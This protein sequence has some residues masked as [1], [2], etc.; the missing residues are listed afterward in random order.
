MIDKHKSLA[1]FF[2]SLCLIG[3]LGYA[4]YRVWQ[5]FAT[6]GQAF[7][8][9]IA[10]EVLAND[11]PE[12][13]S[14]LIEYLLIRSITAS[15]RLNVIA[16]EDLTAYKQKTESSEEETS[17]PIIMITSEVYPKLSG[18]V[19]FVT[20]KYKGRTK[21]VRKFECKGSFDL[22]STQAGRIHSFIADYSDGI[23][24]EIEGG[25]TFSQ[26][27]T[28]NP[29]ALRNF[30]DGEK[31]HKKLETEE[32]IDAYRT[33]LEN[34]AE[35]SLAR[36][37]LADVLVF[38][39]L[40]EDAREN[41]QEAL[42]RKDR[43]I[44]YDLL[45]LRALMSRLN[46]DPIQERQYIR[47]LKEAFPFDKEHHYEFAES[48]FNCGDAEEA[49][50]HYLTALE[51]DPNFSRAHNH[52]AF[53]YSWLGRHVLAEQHFVKYVELDNTAN[54]YDSLASG[55]MFAGKYEE[56][57]EA[58]NKGIIIDPKL[59]YM[60][61]GLARNYIL[62]G[63]LT[64]ARK[65][66]QKDIDV[67]IRENSKANAHFYIAYLELMR[68]NLGRAVQELEPVLDFYANE[69]Y[70]NRIDDLANQPFWL[71]GFIAAER[72][73][74]EKLGDILRI[75]GQ[76][77]VENKVNATNYFP[78]YKFYI[79]LKI[80]EAYLKGDHIEVVRYMDE[81]KRIRDRMGYWY[82]MFDMAFFFDDYARILISL[83][84]WDDA[85]QFLL[86]VVAYNPNYAASRIKLAQVYL[87][88][89][90]LDKAKTHY[91]KAVELLSQANEDYVLINEA[92][93]LGQKLDLR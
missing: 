12:I 16:Q 49:I 76:K 21:P 46:L 48:Y 25:R 8:N 64:E 54:S 37:R 38:M 22:I 44:E 78:I 58:L 35:F 83:N 74:L 51:L 10:I 19:I 65:A 4:S 87:N 67:A 5:G 92:R 73:E 91:K 2:F 41:L 24:G 40:L 29:D 77:I 62:K 26:I 17:Q 32:A 90:N 79:H 14:D 39:S 68:G 84:R 63:F 75:L 20:V 1:L 18:F 34:D 55:F 85:L 61:E 53:C 57:L 93:E 71:M 42:G 81:G 86:S 72:K 52:M 36:L 13:K 69:Q 7:E 45:K 27:C 66:L 28:N 15:T 88:N 82:S 43:L 80:L 70:D 59:S 33:A 60:Y 30:L 23:I 9:F 11:S 3:I 31:A 89:N 6:S 47:Q 56:A 50:K